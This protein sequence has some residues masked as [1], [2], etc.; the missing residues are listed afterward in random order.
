MQRRTATSGRTSTRVQSRTSSP[1]NN[2]RLYAALGHAYL[3]YREAGIDVGE[4]PLEHAERCAQ[5]VHALEPASASGLRLR[6][7]IQYCR[8]R[9]Q[10]AVR[11]LKAALE[12]EPH[13]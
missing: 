3:Q 12:I 11:D 6:G 10:P 2:A 13:N 5:K 9:I 1:F 7:W 4:G 8:G